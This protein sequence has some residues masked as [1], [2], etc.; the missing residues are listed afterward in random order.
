MERTETTNATNTAPVKIAVFASGTGTNA[1]K[2]IDYFSD[3]PVARVALV[4]CNKPG[5]GVLN[6]AEKA[7]I[8]SLLIEK[9]AFFRGDAYLSKLRETGI[10]F[11]VLAGF[12]WKIPQA[13]I[14]AFPR[15]IVN[16]HP[17]LLPK[18]GGKGM[19]GQ[20]VHEAVLQ[21]GERETGITVHYVD[22]HYDSGD[23]IFQT[24]C[25]VVEGDTPE[26]IAQRIHQ[27]EHV[28]YPRVVEEVIKNS[29]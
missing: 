26:T 27:L 20:Y 14:D 1:A 8:P 13:L 28:H 11:L 6:I 24:A 19:Y 4:V 25:P 17:A 23:I 2:L 18:F 22:E 10:G 9:E 16:I 29:P 15:R 12:L 21:A 3:S 5:A 7:G